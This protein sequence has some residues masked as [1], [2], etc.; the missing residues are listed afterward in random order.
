MQHRMDNT[1]KA[2]CICLLTSNNR[3]ATLKAVNH[4]LYCICS[5]IYVVTHL[6]FPRP[7]LLHLNASKTRSPTISLKYRVIWKE[8]K[9]DPSSPVNKTKTLKDKKKWIHNIVIKQKYLIVSREKLTWSSQQPL[10]SK[11]PSSVRL[12][13]QNN[14]KQWV[15]STNGN[16]LSYLTQCFIIRTCIAH[17]WY[18]SN[19]CQDENFWSI[20]K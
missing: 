1:T 13:L 2:I 18:H 19:A 3:R 9:I 10:R 17:E 12:P 15:P 5:V 16:H 6:K 8:I 11:N 4:E 14:K 7:I 20:S